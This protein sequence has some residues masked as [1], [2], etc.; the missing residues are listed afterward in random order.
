MTITHS[1]EYWSSFQ[2]PVW[3]LEDSVTATLRHPQPS[4][5]SV[6]SLPFFL[7]PI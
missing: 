7:L 5:C 1:L 3:E 6:Y 4:Q 2:I